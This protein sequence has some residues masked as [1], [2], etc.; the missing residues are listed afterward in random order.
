MIRQLQGLHCVFVVMWILTLVKSQKNTIAAH[1]WTLSSCTS[2]CVL[3]HYPDFVNAHF[4]LLNS[5]L[6]FSEILSVDDQRMGFIYVT[7]RPQTAETAEQMHQDWLQQ[8]IYAQTSQ[9]CAVSSFWQLWMS[10]FWH[11]SLLSLSLSLWTVTSIN[12]EYRTHTK[13]FRAEC[14]MSSTELW[15]CRERERERR[16]GHSV[17]LH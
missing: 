4:N 11:F 12:A 6:Q 1:T 14:F 10:S 17:S 13:I 8:Y 9:K 16:T 2:M 7:I 3:R 15:R 5:K